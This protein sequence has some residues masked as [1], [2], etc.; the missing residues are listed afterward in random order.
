MQKRKRFS[1]QNEHN[2]SANHF[3]GFFCP[4]HYCQFAP[5]LIVNA[6]SGKQS[7]LDLVKEKDTVRF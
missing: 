4:Q 6:F 7:Y 2:L 3:H 5:S 1:F